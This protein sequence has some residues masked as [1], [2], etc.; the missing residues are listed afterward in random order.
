MGG[1]QKLKNIDR[2]KR[3]N[4]ILRIRSIVELPKFDI[5]NK[6]QKYPNKYFPSDHFSLMVECE[7]NF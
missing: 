1:E 5:F 6:F 3:I 7:F 4:D 2:R